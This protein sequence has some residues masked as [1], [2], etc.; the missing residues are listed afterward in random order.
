M[1]DK[2]V[3]GALGEIKYHD[4]RIKKYNVCTANTL[5]NPSPSHYSTL[6]YCN[7]TLRVEYV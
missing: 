1:K 5:P 2:T 3:A 4:N 6:W 7:I